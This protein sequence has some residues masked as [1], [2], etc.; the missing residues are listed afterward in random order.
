MGELYDQLVQLVN[1][2]VADPGRPISSYSLGHA[3]TR[4]VFPQFRRRSTPPG[5]DQCPWQYGEPAT[6]TPEHPAVIDAAVIWSYRAVQ[7]QMDRLAAWLVERRSARAGRGDLWAPQRLVGLCRDRRLWRPAPAT[8]YSIP[9][10]PSP[11]STRSCASP[12]P[13]LGS[14]SP[15]QD[16]RDRDRRRAERAR[17]R[18]AAH[19]PGF[20]ELD[21]SAA[22]E[23]APDATALQTI[24]D[25]IRPDDFACLTFTSGSTANPRR[26]SGTTAR[27][28]TSFPGRAS[29]SRS[30]AKQLLDAVWAR[31]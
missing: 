6:Q 1:D 22:Q 28:P 16:L 19:D 17:R 24:T 4:E 18:R 23:P 26:S 11:D 8:C 21:A 31:P 5:T 10:T 20:D 7:R 9:S 3:E 12:A 30:T 25:C 13:T 15:L 2:V 29:G 14:R 27:S